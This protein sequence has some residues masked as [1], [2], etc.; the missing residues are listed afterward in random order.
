[1]KH[2]DLLA[3]CFECFSPTLGQ[4]FHFVPPALAHLAHGRRNRYLAPILASHR[5]TSGIRNVRLQC[6]LYRCGFCPIYRRLLL[7][8]EV[9]TPLVAVIVAVPTCSSLSI[10]PTR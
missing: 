3:Q 8:I 6:M 9:G 1:M 10:L 5:D 4:D 7:H 2:A